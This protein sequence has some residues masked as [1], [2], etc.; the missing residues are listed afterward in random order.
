MAGKLRKLRPTPWAL[1]VAAWDIWRRLP[2]QQQ[3]MLMKLA[4][5]HGPKLAARAA[6]AATARTRRSK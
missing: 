4:R 6:K 2:P 3:R 1:T 5:K